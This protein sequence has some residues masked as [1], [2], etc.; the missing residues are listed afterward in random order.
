MMDTTDKV[1]EK[2]VKCNH[3][4]C[5]SLFDNHAYIEG[6]CYDCFFYGPRK[7]KKGVI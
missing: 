1:K 3:P 5:T 2:R 7:K 4:E 6:K